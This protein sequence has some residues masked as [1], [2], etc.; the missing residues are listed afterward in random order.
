VLPFSPS[1]LVAI[2]LA[3]N[4]SE[5]VP[6]ELF[7]LVYL[8]IMNASYAGVDMFRVIYQIYNYSFAIIPTSF[9]DNTL[10][11]YERYAVLGGELSFE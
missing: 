3:T 2:L 1:A 8:S 11:T 4:T 9:L 7:H 6:I 10:T 5:R